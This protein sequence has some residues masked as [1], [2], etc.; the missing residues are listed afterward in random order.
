V[1]ATP[2][3]DLEVERWVTAHRP[4]AVEAIARAVTQL[5]GTPVVATVTVLVA[6]I[7]CW[8]RRRAPAVAAAV[9][10]SCLLGELLVELAARLVKDLV[11]RPRPPF[12]DAVVRL[13]NSSLP[14]AHV[15]RALYAA[16]LVVALASGRRRRFAAGVGAL[17]VVGVGWSRVTLGAHWLTDTL[18]A[19][20]LGAAIAALPAAVV[21]ATGRELRRGGPSPPAGPVEA[22]G[23]RHRLTC[24]EP[25][26]LPPCST[27]EGASGMP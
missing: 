13:A 25:E 24:R 21:V 1:L 20:P 22:S 8:R 18:A 16:A 9:A 10:A 14:A 4:P 5:G 27:T 3:V 15:S 23:V 2:A 11:G 26:G 12:A 6:A 19:V 17:V 7:A